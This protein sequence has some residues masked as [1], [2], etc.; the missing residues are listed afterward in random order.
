[1][2]FYG[3]PAV[4]LKSARRSQD[5]PTGSKSDSALSAKAASIADA[6]ADAVSAPAPPDADD[7]LGDADN[8][9]DSSPPVT[10]FGRSF[11]DSFTSDLAGFHL[12]QT[13]PSPMRRQL[14]NPTT[15]QERARAMEE[16]SSDAAQLAQELL[17]DWRRKRAAFGSPEA[18]AN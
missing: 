11:S 2:Y 16:L 14:S 1:M 8:S 6:D 15:A 5:A 4:P 13:A 17:P 9:L 18:Q 7:D 3:P 10:T 12:P